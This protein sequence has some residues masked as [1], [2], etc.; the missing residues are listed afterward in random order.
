MKQNQTNKEFNNSKKI[1]LKALKKRL[2]Q[3]EEIISKHED[4]TL[5]CFGN[6]FPLCSPS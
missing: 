1:Q 5:F 3:A 6:R 4:R 2:D